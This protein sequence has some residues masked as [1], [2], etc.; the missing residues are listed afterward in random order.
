MFR[1]VPPKMAGM[2][3]AI[4]NSGLQL[5]SAVGLAVDTSIE[6]SVE[7]KHGGFMKYSG[8]AAAF[9]WLL[10]AVIIQTF[11]V[12]IFYRHSETDANSDRQMCSTLG[13]EHKGS[14]ADVSN[15]C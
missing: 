15:T 4:F 8:R 3:G 6:T 11:L 12:L 13:K 14:S 5:G 1:S 10:A 7:E 9:W 2:V